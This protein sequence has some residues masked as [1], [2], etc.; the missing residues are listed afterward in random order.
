[1][2][3]IEGLLDPGARA[4]PVCGTG[5]WSAPGMCNPDNQSPCVDGRPSEMRF[6]SG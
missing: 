1:M 6:R 4:N 2:S 5:Q 3:R